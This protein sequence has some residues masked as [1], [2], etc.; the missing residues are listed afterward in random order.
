MG[1]PPLLDQLRWQTRAIGNFVQILNSLFRLGFARVGGIS[2]RVFA[3]RTES[4][5]DS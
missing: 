2:A 4:R 3:V 5:R 1:G